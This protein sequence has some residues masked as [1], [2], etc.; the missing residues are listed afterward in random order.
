M[1]QKYLFYL[2]FLFS[3]GNPSN[4]DKKI[5]IND[6]LKSTKLSQV[7]I[8]GKFTGLMS[9][10]LNLTSCDY[11]GENYMVYDHTG[12]LDSVFAFVERKRW[13]FPFV[14][15]VLGQLSKKDNSSIEGRLDVDSIIFTEEKN[16]KNTCIP[17]D[18][19]CIG[20]EPFWQVQISAQE[21]LID[22]YDPMAQKYYV[23]N[24][25]VSKVENSIAIYQSQNKS[26]K[27]KITINKG[28]C[29]DGMSDR[30]Y[31]YSVIVNLNDKEYKGCAIKF[32]E[33]IE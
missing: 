7:V 29:T 1:K 5:I 2:I 16:Y 15:Q 10:N 21:N 26:D 31:N 25:M 22:F 24:Y 32:G 4:I 3:C 20:N 9:G 6:S 17:Y 18:F 12:G 14:I 28:K 27:I 8:T 33:I 11:L 30:S 23:F 13:K 19:W